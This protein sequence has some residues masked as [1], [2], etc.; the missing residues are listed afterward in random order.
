M[1]RKHD[2]S[3]ASSI[4]L[5]CDHHPY[6]TPYSKEMDQAIKLYVEEGAQ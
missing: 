3:Q 2:K 6:L 4:L 1:L 5:I